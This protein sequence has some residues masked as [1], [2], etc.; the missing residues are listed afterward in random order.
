MHTSFYFHVKT[1]ET[2]AEKYYKNQKKSTKKSA[3]ELSI[4]QVLPLAKG[5]QTWSDSHF[6]GIL[7]KPMQLRKKKARSGVA[8][9][10]SAACFEFMSGDWAEGVRCTSR[11]GEA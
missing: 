2:K 10:F 8:H 5:F 7:I 11:S 4:P 3:A 6:F 9:K 1:P